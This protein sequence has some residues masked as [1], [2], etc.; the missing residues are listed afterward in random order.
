MCRYLVRT[1][2]GKKSVLHRPA[3]ASDWQHPKKGKDSDWSCFRRKTKRADWPPP[4]K[5]MSL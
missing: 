3:V 2:D 5:G 4:E 1:S